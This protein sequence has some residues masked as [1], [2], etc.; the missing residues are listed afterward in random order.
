MEVWEAIVPYLSGLVL[1]GGAIG[2]VVKWIAPALKLAREV[3]ALA[4]RV[5]ELEEHDR[6]D[7]KFQKVQLKATLSMV[8]HIIDGNGIDSLKN[9]RNEL[10]DLLVQ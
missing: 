9:T 8:N 7:R 3:K 10:Q 6:S 5:D 2:V 1:L 4:L